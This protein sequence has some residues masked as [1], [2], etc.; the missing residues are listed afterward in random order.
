MA[1]ARRGASSVKK[2]SKYRR[3]RKNDLKKYG[4]KL[5]IGTALGLAVSIPLTLLARHTNRPELMEVGQRAGSIISSTQGPVGNAGYQ[6]GDALFDRF[7][8][9]QGSPISGTPG[10]VYL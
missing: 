4:K 9:Y 8:V 10:N 7:V 6:L 1:L 5:A 3:P 2:K